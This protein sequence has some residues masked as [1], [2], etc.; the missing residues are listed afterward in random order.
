MKILISGGRDDYLNKKGYQYLNQLHEQYD[1]T[2][3]VNGMATGI[4][5]CARIWAE[6][7]NIPV[8]PFP[9]KWNDLKNVPK[10]FIKTNKYGKEYN[11]KAG[12]DRNKYMLDYLDEGDLVVVMPGGAGSTHMLWI[13][14]GRDDVV[15]IN[16]MERE[17][18]IEK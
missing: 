11:A 7:H 1:F 9:A 8:K 10:M 4:D 3:I 18:L 5:K 14:N 15:V 17:D 12:T 16:L 13:A 2:E 6:K